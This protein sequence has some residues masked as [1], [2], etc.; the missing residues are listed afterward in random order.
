MFYWI[1]DYPTWAMAL[2]FGFVFVGL[3]L[4]GLFV[5]RALLAKWIHT[6]A[7]TNELVGVSLASFA[8][9]YGILLGLVAVGAYENY[10]AMGDLVAKEASCVAS[11]YRDA[12]AF[13]E[14]YRGTLQRDLRT[15]VRQTVDMGWPAQ[16][17][18]LVPTG[19][20]QIVTTLFGDLTAFNPGDKRGEL[21]FAETFRQFNSLVELRRARLA[22]VNNGIPAILWWVVGIGAVLT[23]VLIWMMDME[24]HV[25]VMLTTILSLFLAA[26]IFLVIAMDN[27][28]RGEVSVGPEA[29]ERVYQ[30]LMQ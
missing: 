11:L 12:S 19:G 22:A 4:I 16:R 29:F 25:H 3:S 15:Y 23:L 2:L 10:A 7:R 13:P 5:F 14:P 26:V 20:S 27:P 28:F 8:V 24:T 1:Y 17:Q 9:L 6:E 21:I 30:T 18:G